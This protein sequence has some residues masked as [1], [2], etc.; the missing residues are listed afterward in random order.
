[1]KQ[2]NG[3]A[4]I[5]AVVLLLAGA[6]AVCAAPIVQDVQV[7]HSGM[8][9]SDA[10]YVLAHTR[11]RV[12][13]ELNAKTVSQ[14]VKQL[15]ATG[16]FTVVDAEVEELEDGV[17]L[18]YTVQAKLLLEA[19]PEVLGVSEFSD[20]KVRKW[21]ALS[22]GQLVDD[23]TVGVAV[24]EVLKEYREESYGDATAVWAFEPVDRSTGLVRLS[25]TF[26]E[27]PVSYIGDVRV[28]GN[29]ILSAGDLRTA[30]TRPSPWNPIRWFWKKRYERFELDDIEAGVKERYMDHGFFDVQ[31]S[32]SVGEAQDKGKSV[33][34]V[35]VDEGTQY[36][37]GTIALSGVTLFPEQELRG[38]ITLSTG[39][40]ASMSGIGAMADRLQTYYGD[41][42]YLHAGARFSLDPNKERGIVDLAFTIREG[43]LV[44]IRNV[45]I[46]GNTRTKDEVIRRELH[47]YPGEVYN[48]TRVRRSERRINNL[49]FFESVRALPEET[50][51]PAQ[52]DLVFDVAEK[53]TGQF[54]LGAGFSSVDNLI[55][56]AELSQGNFDLLGWPHFT[57]DGQKLRLRAQFGSTRKAYELSIIEPWFLDRRLSLGFDVYR[58]DRN[59]SDYD[60]E[61]TGASL[62]L[63]KALPGPNRITF[64]YNIEESVITD[65]SDT[66]TY[67][68]LD[69]YDFASDTGTEYLFE[70]EQD[71]IKSTLSAT[72]L[73]DTRNNPFVPTKGNKISLFYSVSGG[74]LGFDT[75]IYDVGIRSTSYVPLWFGHVFNLRTRVE[76]VE[77]FGDSETVPLTDRLFLGG[78]RTLRGFDYRDVGPKVIRENGSS[79]HARSFGGQ[80]LFMVNA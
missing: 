46:R 48:Q 42:G 34:I 39:K 36:R 40:V 19:E 45:I 7:K 2:L 30:L 21:L 55:G 53:R 8:G 61:R 75:D 58:R 6:F 23:Q 24:R 28:Q 54:M 31:V 77:A 76:F 72:L 59:Y 1:M 14:E 25:I 64:R 52:R 41:R 68:E 67:Y 33:A 65:V 20:S 16:K 69:S 13:H 3:K 35:V 79:Y 10:E 17:R 12:G 74:P 66:N 44:H 5:C 22:E 57:G 51:T 37:V 71:R 50:G 38:L 47:V 11:T 62:S 70:S 15:L 78:G 9:K 32:A 60:I 43:E 49:G 56:F 73:H 63:G 80:S 18:T 4:G 26:T 29:K 27:G